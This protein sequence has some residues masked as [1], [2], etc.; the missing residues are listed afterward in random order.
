MLHPAADSSNG[1]SPP[2]SSGRCSAA[3]ATSPVGEPFSRAHSAVIS[4]T[5]LCRNLN[6]HANAAAERDPLRRAFAPIFLPIGCAARNQLPYDMEGN[7]SWTLS[8]GPDVAVVPLRGPER[9]GFEL[10]MGI[11]K[12]SWALANQSPLPPTDPGRSLHEGSKFVGIFSICVGE[13]PRRVASHPRLKEGRVVS[14]NNMGMA[15]PEI[16]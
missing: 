14:F 3:A 15:G 10:W 7:R 11:D 1:T 16:T 12:L 4:S 6:S 8:K 13:R 5:M 9:W 2:F